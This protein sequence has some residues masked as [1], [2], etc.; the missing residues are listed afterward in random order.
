MDGQTIICPFCRSETILQTSS[1]TDLPDDIT[2]LARLQMPLDHI[3]SESHFNVPNVCEAHLLCDE[4]CNETANNYCMECD[5]RMCDML[6]QYIARS[7]P[8][9]VT[10]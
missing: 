10:L 2:T 8:V 6:S 9:E 5:Q 4:L 1:I 7:L 3:S